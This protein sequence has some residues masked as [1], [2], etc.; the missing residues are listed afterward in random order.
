MVPV[1]PGSV[2]ISQAMLASRLLLLRAWT[3]ATAPTGP[4]GA[5]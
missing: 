1:P 3:G 4:P 5:W 2:A